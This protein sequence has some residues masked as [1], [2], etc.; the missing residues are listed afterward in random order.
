MPRKK[1]DVFRR[2]TN[3]HLQAIGRVAA[4]WSLLELMVLSALSTISGIR[5]DKA[6]ILAGP[7]AFASWLDMLAILARNSAEHKHIEYELDALFKLLKKLLNRRNHIVHAVWQIPRVGGPGLINSYI[8]P[9]TARSKIEA[10]GF[11]KRGKEWIIRVA[12]T[13]KQMRHVATLIAKARIMLLE[14]Q[15]RTPP[16]SPK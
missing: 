9:L 6:I 16:T 1:A 10:D 8:A 14:I 11:P 2:L 12:W 15:M 5:L 13:P 3:S 4:T 7:S